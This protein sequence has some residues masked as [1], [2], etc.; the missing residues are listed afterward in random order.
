MI[1][2]NRGQ[3]IQIGAVLLFGVL[4]IGLSVWQA[5]IIPSQNENVEFNHNEDVQDQMNELRSTINSMADASITRSTNIDTGVRYP[6]RTIFRNPPPVSGIIQTYETDNE[7][8]N[9]TIKNASPREENLGNLWDLQTGKSTTGIYNTGSIQYVPQYNEYNNPPR[10]IYEHSIVYNKFD[11]E[12]ST[13]PISGQSLIDGN[14]INLISLTGDINEERIDSTSIDIQPISTRTKT[15]TIEPDIDEV[16]GERQPVTIDIP[17]RLNE[18]QWNQAISDRHSV[19]T[20]ENEEDPFSENDEIQTI[21]IEMDEDSPRDSYRLQLSKVGIG[22][23][24]SETN[25]KYLSMRDGNRGTITQGESQT[26]RLE[27]RNEFNKPL[28]DIDVNGEIIEGGGELNSN[29]IKSN[30]QGESIF[31]FDSSEVDIN[32][33]EEIDVLIEFEIDG[34]E[35]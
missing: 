33:Y 16:T 25:P 13:L 6:S 35:I 18:F 17:T 31:E 22:S 20:L 28:T 23:E 15:V 2:D 30:S 3:S 7:N 21:R 8:F 1:E 24:R 29:T 12:G 27:T 11:R 26:F 19:N 10:T 9:F 14:Q 34:P 32:E 4:I 5:S